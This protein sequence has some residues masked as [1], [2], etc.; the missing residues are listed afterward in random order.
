MRKKVVIDGWPSYD[1]SEFLWKKHMPEVKPE[2]R[3]SVYA[4]PT[5]FDG[6]KKTI[7]YFDYKEASDE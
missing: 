3:D 2:N 1:S 5:V 4:M 7:L 6:H